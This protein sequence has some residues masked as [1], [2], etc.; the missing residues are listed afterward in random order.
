ML[1]SNNIQPEANHVIAPCPLAVA[2]FASFKFCNIKKENSD[3]PNKK[4]NG[5]KGYSQC[6]SAGHSHKREKWPGAIKQQLRM[7]T[8]AHPQPSLCEEQKPP[9]P[10]KAWWAHV[11]SPPPPPALCQSATCGRRRDREEERNTDRL[12]LKVRTPFKLRNPPF[13][14]N[15]SAVCSPLSSPPIYQCLQSSSHSNPQRSVGHLTKAAL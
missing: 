12:N 10:H 4:I 1:Q 8:R 15:A 13:P 7:A 3:I 2:P 9:R 6:S 11:S 14:C 5:V